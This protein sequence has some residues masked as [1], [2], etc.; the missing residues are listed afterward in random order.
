ML[1]S[2]SSAK[3][4]KT[5]APRHKFTRLTESRRRC[6]D[7][8]VA[9]VPR[10]DLHLPRHRDFRFNTRGI[11]REG[12]LWNSDSNHSMELKISCGGNGTLWRVHVDN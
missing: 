12:R 3:A 8:S 6:R 7:S 5:V 9:F 4:E 1:H 10:A 2:V 11:G